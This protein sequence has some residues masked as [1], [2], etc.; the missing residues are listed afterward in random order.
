MASANC[1]ACQESNATPLNP[2][3]WQTKHPNEAWAEG[4]LTPISALETLKAGDDL[5]IDLVLAEPEIEQPVFLNFDERGRMW[6]VEYRQ[7]PHPAGLKI[8]SRDSVWRNVYDRVPPPPPHAVD[9]PF[10]GADRISIH[11]DT[12]GD[13]RFES[14][15]TFLE[16]LSLATSVAHGRGGVWVL[17]PPYL[18]FYPDEDRNDLPD[19]PPTVHLKGFGLEDSHSI[20]NSLRWGPDGWL[21]AAQGSTVSSDVVVIGEDGRESDV[22]HTQGQQIWRY[23]PEQRIFEVFAEGGGNAFG[24]EIDQKGRVFSGHNGGDARGFHYVQGGYLRKGFNKHGDHSNRFAYGYFPHM[25]HEK[26]KRFTHNFIVYE[27]ASLP[28]QYRGKLFGVDPINRYVPV[29]DRIEQGSTFATSDVSAAVMTEDEW[30]RPVDIKH[31]PDGFVYVADWYDKQ[32]NHFRNHEGK[33]D[34]RRGRIYRL[35]NSDPKFSKFPDLNQ[36]STVQLLEWLRHPNRWCREQARRIMGDRRDLSAIPIMKKMIFESDGQLALELLWG[37]NL[38]GGFNEEVAAELLQ[39]ADPFVRAWTVRLLGD[40]K[41]VSRVIANQLA[42]LAA[43]EPHPE[44]RSQLA[45]TAKRLPADSAIPIVASLLSRDEDLTD[46]YI[47]LQIWWALESKCETHGDSVVEMFLESKLWQRPIV[48]N[49]ILWR[50]MSRFAAVGQR[51][52]MI[53]CARLLELAPDKESKTRLMAGFEHAFSGRALTG[54]PIQLVKAIGDAGGASLALRIRNGDHEAIAEALEV[55]ADSNQLLT[56]RITYLALFGEINVPQAI[57]SMIELVADEES[58][59]AQTALASLQSYADPKIGAAVIAQFNSLDQLSREIATALLISR[60]EFAN[61]LIDSIVDGRIDKDIFA[62]EKVSQLRLLQDTKLLARVNDVWGKLRLPTPEHFQKEINRVADVIASG[63]SNPYD[64][65]P[66][67]TDRC[68]SCHRLYSSGGNIG[69]DLTSYQ[70]SNK[71]T[72]LLHIINPGSEIREGFE[73]FVV[74]TEDGRVVTG[75]KAD[76]DEKVLV[77]RVAEGQAVS[78]NKE[79]VDEIKPSVK[80]LMPDGLLTD[81]SDQQ[82]RDLF[83]Y[84]QTTQPLVGEKQFREQQL[85]EKQRQE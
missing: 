56:R 5:S 8:L 21:Y 34:K 32:V 74:L 11:E 81:L 73:S 58:E 47:P 65:K 1:L 33:I 63:K 31:G 39:H 78:L 12:D 62:S 19:G 6:V 7:Y 41:I 3:G 66:I 26:V 40:K 60:V 80:S 53:R 68:G 20:C 72:M 13:G 37:L 84:F 49:E 35:R 46:R 48:Q 75:F 25:P 71:E 30:F 16:G 24:C 17:N 79:E 82:L 43:Q 18:M 23:H 2:D 4:S 52:E 28:A 10:R 14:S 9:S 54:L 44:V 22:I 57:D 50:L 15:K 67:F 45:A 85:L 70:R 27:G 83:A 42:A 76:E 51:R 69:P 38:S 64:G 61:E 59:I 36:S 77:I 55:V 29:V